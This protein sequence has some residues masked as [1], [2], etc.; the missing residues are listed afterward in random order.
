M[1]EAALYMRV[2]AQFWKER[3]DDPVSQVC[4]FGRVWRAMRSVHCSVK[5]PDVGCMRSV[6]CEHC[7]PVSCN[8][9]NCALV[10]SL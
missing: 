10:Y 3:R 4:M 1:Q 5:C 9:R 8:A 7:A 6:Q 2:L